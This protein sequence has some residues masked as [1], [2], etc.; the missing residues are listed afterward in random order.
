[1]SV[2]GGG[3]PARDQHAYLFEAKGIQKWILEGGRLRDIA[4]A[5]NLLARCASSD[6]EDILASVIGQTA[7]KPRFSRRAGGA[8]ML[9]YAASECANFE[10]FRALWRL[11]FMQIAPGLEFVESFGQGRSDL[12]ARD[13]AYRGGGQRRYAGRENA[14]AALLPLG[15]PL[16]AL[17]QRTGRPAVDAIRFGDGSAEYADLTGTSKWRADGAGGERVGA[18][19]VS[20]EER[21]LWPN[22]MDVDPPGGAEDESSDD[23]SDHGTVRSREV[24]FPFEGEARWIAVMHADISAL[25]AFYEAVGDAVRAQSTNPETA[26]GIAFGAAAAIE[27]AVT[28][29]ALRA[30]AEVL[31]PRARNTA[32]GE[33]IMPA[34]PILLGGDDITVI[35]RG[36][37]ALPFTRVFLEALEV[38]S[39]KHLRSFASPFKLD[40]NT[41][42]VT[43]LSAAAGV[44]FGKSKQPFFRLLELAES[45]CGHAKR[46]AKDA[47]RDGQR[48][49]SMLAFHRVTESALGGD[50]GVLFERL[51]ISGTRRLTA[52]PYLVGTLPADGFARLEDLD[53]LRAAIALPDL[54]SGKLRELRALLLQKFEVEGEEAWQ[55]WQKLASSRA[56]GDFAQFKSALQKMLNETGEA[57]G[58]L[59]MFGASGV[60]AGATP[61]FDAIE[62]E[63]VQ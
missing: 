15:H 46:Q 25:G 16:I 57:P 55:R 2:N 49:A 1:M 36:D 41:S 3:A 10:R 54:K 26:R 33:W 9:H 19:F 31:L 12:E 60:L 23:A 17:A 48:P 11:T 7:L 40:R 20:G 47:C 8:F 32:S 24:A 61:I 62:W 43:N 45:L 39:E 53:A 18:K 27:K 56:A 14:A 34:R 5:S 6:G 58:G 42:L 35:L 52:Q 4:A 37:A 38:E 29:A 63:A 50:A 51:K 21:I 30:T 44:A 13:D 59:P 22:Q 28:A